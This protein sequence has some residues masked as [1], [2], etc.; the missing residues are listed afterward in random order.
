MT[1]YPDVCL[2]FRIYKLFCLMKC[3]P[4]SSNRIRAARKSTHSE[5]INAIP[6][7]SPPTVNQYQY[8]FASPILGPSWVILCPPW[9]FLGGPEGHLEAYFGFGRLALGVQG[10][11]KLRCQKHDFALSKSMFLAAF[12]R[13]EAIRKLAKRLFGGFLAARML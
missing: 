7:N 11:Q 9:P 1:D 8:L 2:R 4:K 10:G 5:P 12:W 3:L 6:R 13:R